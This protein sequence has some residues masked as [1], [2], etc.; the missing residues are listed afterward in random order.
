VRVK[1]A[2][3]IGINYIGS[4]HSLQGCIN[5]VKHERNVLTTHFGFPDENIMVLSDDQ[6]DRSK[7]PTK[8]NMLAGIRW[9]MDGAS[10]GDVLYFHYSGHGSQVPDPTGEEE[11]GKNECLCPSDCLPMGVKK[12]PGA[13]IVDD[14]LNDVFFDDL[15]EGV[16]LTC[17]YDCCHSGTMTDLD[18]QLELDDDEAAGGYYGASRSLDGITGLREGDQP[19][20][21]PPPHNLHEVLQNQNALK[22]PQKRA[23]RPEGNKLI[24]TVSGCQD[25]QTSADATINGVKQ[26]ALTW[27][28]HSALESCNYDVTYEE[29]LHMC[30]KKLKR[31]Y[32]QIPSMSTTVPENFKC[33]FLGAGLASVY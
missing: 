21:M 7:H 16:R 20:A 30:R 23:L 4:Q 17:V 12:W 19:R 6:H 33:K 18:Y 25:N 2:L 5:D 24:W 29:L 28:L 31:K 22:Q 10:R 14:Y 15:P 13:V 26:G 11:D 27:S 1:K 8:A 9:L 3:L 32:T